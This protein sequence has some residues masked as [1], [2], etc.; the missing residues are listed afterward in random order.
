MKKVDERVLDFLCSPS[1]MNTDSSCAPKWESWAHL[2]FMNL[3]VAVALS[4][5]YDPEL[6]PKRYKNLYVPVMSETPAEY[7]NRFKVAVE[8]F[9]SGALN[10]DVRS[11]NIS[12][13]IAW[14][15]A[16]PSPWEMPEEFEAFK[17]RSAESSPQHLFIAVTTDP[18]S[19]KAE[20]KNRAA[21]N[22]KGLYTVREAALTL[23]KAHNLKAEK[24]RQDMISAFYDGTL[25]VL[26]PDTEGPLRKGS[27]C[28]DFYNLV[29]A[30][31][32]N[33]WLKCVGFAPHVRWP[34]NVVTEIAP[35]AAE[36]PELPPLLSLPTTTIAQIFDGLPFPAKRWSSNLSAA[37]W[38]LPANR[39]KGERGGAPAMWCPLT[40]A[41]LVCEREKDARTKQKTLK[42]LNSRFRINPVLSPWKDAWD[43]YFGMF[44]EHGEA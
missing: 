2:D 40:I 16:L 29:T 17:E 38:L 18:E 22:A 11:V 21:Q 30:E 28:R 42:S 6:L 14:A 9:E 27:Q 7:Q 13:F 8:G 35:R 31:S 43:D 32:V 41:Q 10:G 26:D 34:E 15:D 20:E 19:A 39:G 44:T 37:K 24:L 23:A 5:N 25:V 1:Y 3:Y 4:L 12:Q 36:R 33:D